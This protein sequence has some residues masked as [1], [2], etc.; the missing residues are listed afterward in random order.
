MYIKYGIE[1]CP[2]GISIIE[3]LNKKQKPLTSG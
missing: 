1:I 3:N 2:V